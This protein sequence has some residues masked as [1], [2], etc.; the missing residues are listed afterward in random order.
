MALAMKTTEREVPLRLESRALK[1]LYRVAH[2][3][4]NSR[5]SRFSELL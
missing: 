4:R 5:Y 3:K 1:A 2:K